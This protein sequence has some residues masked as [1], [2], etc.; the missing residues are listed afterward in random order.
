MFKKLTNTYTLGIERYK[1]ID[2]AWESALLRGRIS[3]LE[4]KP[5][6][7]FATAE[8]HLDRLRDLDETGR[9]NLSAIFNNARNSSLYIGRYTSLEEAAAYIKTLESYFGNTLRDHGAAERVLRDGRLHSTNNETARTFG[10]ALKRAR[11]DEIFTLLRAGTPVPF[12]QIAG[13]LLRPLANAM[14]VPYT[15]EVERFTD[16]KR[17]LNSV[18]YK[19]EGLASFSFYDNGPGNFPNV[20]R[21]SYNE[22]NRTY[23]QTY[24][25][26]GTLD[27]LQRNVF[28]WLADA[29]R[30]RAPTGPAVPAALVRNLNYDELTTY[31]AP[32]QNDSL[33]R[34]IRRG[35]R[36][37]I[38]TA[39]NRGPLPDAMMREYHA[40]TGIPAEK[41]AARGMG[42]RLVK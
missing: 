21:R 2:Y 36:D 39:A 19:F 33:W 34:A 18:T 10:E 26:P 30:E 32:G 1:S 6:D 11:N 31:A 42:L 35:E 12:E 14:N 13:R 29:L 8:P 22:S 38:F 41:P 15:E 17:R 9:D 25:G 40:I 20:I 5:D 16:D 3:A 24:A 28:S 7:F 37:D 23:V 4:E 27:N